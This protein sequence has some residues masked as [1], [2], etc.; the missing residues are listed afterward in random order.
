MPN[1]ARRVVFL[2]LGIGRCKLGVDPMAL[3]L[4][5][6][7]TTAVSV[8][9]AM[10]SVFVI[11]RRWSF[12]GEGV[13][14]SGFGGVG[15]V[16]ILTAL[17]PSL[18]GTSYDALTLL[19]SIAVPVFAAIGM[20]VLSRRGALSGDASIGIFLVACMAIGFVGQNAYLRTFNSDPAVI[21]TLFYGTPLSLSRE[22]TIGAIAMSA[23]VVLSVLVLRRELVAYCLDP[24]LAETSGVRVGFIHY[25]LI[26]MIALV[27]VIGVRIVGILLI[28]ALLVL[29]GATSSLLT[30][31]LRG[32]MLGSV[33]TGVVGAWMG[34]AIARKWD[35]IP[36][37][38]AIVLSLFT[39][40]AVTWCG[41]RIR[42]RT[43]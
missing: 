15:L 16:C 38:S 20:G 23:G 31:R 1:G 34:I 36:M 12:L 28:S 13:G 25:L 10:L 33:A 39:V 37:G 4:T 2:P 42:A 32:A 21:D 40:F 8:A 5:I 7:A 6:L 14:H 17:V 19:A 26:V 29:P 22:F 30:R 3:L 11:A 24:L 9:C 43:P 18:R 41:T 35:I 27:V